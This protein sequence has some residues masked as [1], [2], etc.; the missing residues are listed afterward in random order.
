MEQ[1]KETP[2]TS[3]QTRDNCSVLNCSGNTLENPVII[4]IFLTKD[5]DVETIANILS[6]VKSAFPD[7]SRETTEN[8]Q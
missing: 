4:N 2:A 8:T 1:K 5:A 7:I 6:A 3:I